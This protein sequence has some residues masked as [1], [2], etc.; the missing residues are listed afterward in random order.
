MIDAA[1][2]H[3]FKELDHIKDEA[4]IRILEYWDG[5][6]TYK[7]LFGILSM[8]KVR[9]EGW[10]KKGETLFERLRDYII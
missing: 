8:T 7:Q 5:E 4:A 10:K 6:I 1:F 9:Y 3:W 2:L